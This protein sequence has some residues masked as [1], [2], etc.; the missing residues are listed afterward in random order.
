MTVTTPSRSA[1]PVKKPTGFAPLAKR[2]R[3][4]DHIVRTSVIAALLIA[5]VPLVWLVA[6]LVIRGIEPLLDIDWW[7]LPERKGGAANAIVGTLMQTALAAVISIPLG[8]FVAIYLVEYATKKSL[9]ARVTTFMVDILSGVPSIVAALFVYAVWRTS[10]GLPRSGFVVAIALVLLMVPL[11]VRATEEMLKIVPQ[12]LREASYALGIPKWK[13]IVKIVLPTALSGIVTGVMLAIAR[14]MGESAPVL[15]L[16]G[17]TRA[18]NWNPFEGNQESLPLMMV[19]QYNNGPGVFDKVWGAALCLVI[20]VAI[21]YVG[22]K[23]V[24]KIFA[25]KTS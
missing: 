19:Q 20:L 14:V 12:D 15:I 1:D 21:V 9:L 6:T 3:L 2:R 10:L 7:T 11:V 25:P 17:S 16:V 22:A 18:M 5:L 13:T 24:S 23:V 8:I 4:T